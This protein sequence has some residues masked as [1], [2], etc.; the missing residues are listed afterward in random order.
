[1]DLKMSSTSFD[2]LVEGSDLQIVE[3]KDAT[4]QYLKQ[5]LA[6]FKGEWFLNTEFGIDYYGKVLIKNPDPNVLES[7][8]KLAIL[9]VPGV[10]NLIE[11]QLLVDPATREYEIDF[12]VDTDEGTI[13][14][15]EDIT[16]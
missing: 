14:F 11:F 16:P 7:E 4:V 1:M 3:G 2:I 8:F 5:V 10:R 9:D 12:T 13:S 15:R 6:A